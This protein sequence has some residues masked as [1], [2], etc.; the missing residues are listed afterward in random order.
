MLSDLVPCRTKTSPFIRTSAALCPDPPR[1]PAPSTSPLS[2]KAS[3]VLKSLPR[4]S[5]V[6]PL[7]PRSSRLPLPW[8][9][10]LTNGMRFSQPRSF[11]SARFAGQRAVSSRPRSFGQ[12]L[13]ND[14]G[15]MSSRLFGTAHAA[16]SRLWQRLAVLCLKSA[17]FRLLKQRKLG[18]NARNTFQAS[19][20]E[21]QTRTEVGSSFFVLGGAS[22]SLSVATVGPGTSQD[23]PLTE[24]RGW[25]SAFSGHAEPPRVGRPARSA[26]KPTPKNLKSRTRS[27][28]S[29]SITKKSDK[30]QL[31]QKPSTRAIQTQ[32]RKCPC[33]YEANPT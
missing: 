8:A 15:Q 10:A 9:L 13:H 4:C 6:P 30:T 19:N 16:R 11:R 12:E 31:P 5:E 21:R 28:R 18:R 27:G 29:G 14:S 32:A 3:A 1:G 22:P 23:R 2:C 25:P 17:R 26:R 7:R 24:K 33:R 20:P